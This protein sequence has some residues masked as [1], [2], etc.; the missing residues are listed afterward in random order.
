MIF[1]S[2]LYKLTVNYLQYLLKEHCKSEGLDYIGNKFMIIMYSKLKYCPHKT[3][4]YTIQWGLCNLKLYGIII[5]A[6]DDQYSWAER[7]ALPFPPGA[8]LASGRF[9]M[10]LVLMLYLPIIYTDTIE[11]EVHS[12]YFAVWDLCHGSRSSSLPFR[13]LKEIDEL[14]LSVTY[15]LQTQTASKGRRKETE[16]SSKLLNH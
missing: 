16:R 8:E 9:R 2:A 6:L 1:T 5:L 4:K 14:L 11:V 10:Q 7:C 3:C 13:R 15:R 12:C